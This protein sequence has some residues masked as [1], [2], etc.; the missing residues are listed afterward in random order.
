MAKSTA[1]SRRVDPAD[2]PEPQNTAEFRAQVAQ[3]T[4]DEEVA[5]RAGVST[6]TLK[7]WIKAGAIPQ[8]D[9]TWTTAAVA[10]A[11]IVGQLRKSGQ[12]LD[13]IVKAAGDGRL[14]LGGVDALFAVES[15]RY[16]LKEAAKAAGVKLDVAEQIWISL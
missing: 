10:H 5:E 2:L 11:R 14:A 16:T 4:T 13:E 12:S 3:L 9:G 1:K 7:R 6:A 8:Y 15:K